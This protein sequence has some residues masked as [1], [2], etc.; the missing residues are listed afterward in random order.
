M[1][2]SSLLEIIRTFTK[3]ELIKFEDFVR[4]PYFN[5]KENVINLFLEIKKYSPDYENENLKKEKFVRRYSLTR[6]TIMVS[7]KI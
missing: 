2:K 7:L 5:K 1:L 3:Q 6:N 4:S